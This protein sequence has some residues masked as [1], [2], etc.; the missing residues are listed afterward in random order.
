M[1][2]EPTLEEIEDY[3]DHESPKKR[4]TIR[5]V[6]IFCLLLGVIF[7]LIKYNY[8]TV[9]DYIGTPENP[10]INTTKNL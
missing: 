5:V 1:E 3:N 6:I 9:K 2:N 4:D 8:S 7:T 10:G